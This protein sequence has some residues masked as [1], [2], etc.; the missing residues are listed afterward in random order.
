MSNNL[1]QSPFYISRDYARLY[2]LVTEEDHQI[3]C[4]IIPSGLDYIYFEACIA[5]RYG[6]NVLVENPICNYFLNSCVGN[7][8]DDQSRFLSFCSENSL[9]WIPPILKRYSA[10]LADIADLLD[11]NTPTVLSTLS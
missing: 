10:D 8:C 3:H 2:R 11:L 7:N 4:F 9:I 6:E 5:S 1:I